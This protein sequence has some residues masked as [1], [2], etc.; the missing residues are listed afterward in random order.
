MSKYTHFITNQREPVEVTDSF[1]SQPHTEIFDSYQVI[2]IADRELNLEGQYLADFQFVKR[3]I[4]HLMGK[5][6]TVVEAT[7]PSDG[8]A[9]AI[10]DIMR[11]H[12]SDEL[13]FVSEHMF[14]QN[15]LNRMIPTIE[16]GTPIPAPIDIE[17][18]LDN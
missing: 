11:G 8:Q 12:F 13:S 16:P 1:S 18:V 3:V 14:D 7:T 15:E 17:T 5:V 2:P 10:K 6:L 4:G 9:K